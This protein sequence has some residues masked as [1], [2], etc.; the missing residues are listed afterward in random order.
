[1]VNIGDG[2]WHF[3]AITWRSSDGSVMV[4][5]NGRVACDSGP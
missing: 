3:I 1:M 5:D 2:E 4:H